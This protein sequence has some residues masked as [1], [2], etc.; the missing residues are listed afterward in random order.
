MKYTPSNIIGDAGEHLLAAKVIKLF[1]FPCRLVN[2][3][4]GI[5]AEIEIIDRN[6]KSTGQFI[7]AQVKTTIKETFHLYLSEKHLNYWNTMQVPAVIFLVHLNSENI[8]WHCVDKTEKYLKSKSGLKIDFDAENIL[9]AKNRAKFL[10]ISQYQDQQIL[11]SIYQCAYEIS[12]ED[13]EL[14][15]SGVYDL[16]SFE[17]FVYNCNKILYDFN[18]ADKLIRK[19]P[20]LEK[21]RNEFGSKIKDIKIYLA[22]VEEEK[23]SI[24]EDHGSD[25]F[26]HLKEDQWNWD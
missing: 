20:G 11:A 7:R 9:I 21:I 16:T 23:H 22:R 4:I 3:D 26:D 13:L 6:Y 10:E 25:Y 8:Y 5:D 18:K 17:E 1:G 12:C 24:L 2:I 15:E 19:Q 14:M